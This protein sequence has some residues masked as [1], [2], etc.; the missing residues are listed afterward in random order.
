MDDSLDEIKFQVLNTINKL[1][2]PFVINDIET[3]IENFFKDIDEDS[4][5]EKIYTFIFD[6]LYENNL[7]Y[8]VDW[9]WDIAELLENIRS[10]I[11][12]FDYEII[13]MSQDDEFRAS[14]IIRVNGKEY[15]LVKSTEYEFF[16]E[17]NNILEE[18]GDLKRVLIVEGGTGDTL[19]YS[20]V[21]ASN[22]SF[23]SNN[24]FLPYVYVD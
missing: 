14:G 17:I 3:S 6:Q 16:L 19:F 22:F 4:D 21:L 24:D 20:I 8:A 7:I 15:E 11:P 10:K 23:L 12:D 18:I 9:K 2:E 5:I 13:E 1:T